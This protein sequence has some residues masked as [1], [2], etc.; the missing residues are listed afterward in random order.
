MR[1]QRPLDLKSIRDDARLAGAIGPI[2]RIAIFHGIICLCHLD[3]D[4][5]R[6]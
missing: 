5:Y 2:D 6:R 1:Q 3:A 4:S